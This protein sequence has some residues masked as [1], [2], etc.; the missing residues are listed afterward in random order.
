[1]T[2]ATT[3]TAFRNAPS[4]PNLGQAAVAPRAGRR[5]EL[6]PKLSFHIYGDLAAVESDWRRFERRADC[7]AFQTF[8][9]LASW[10]RHVGAREGVRPAIIVGRY[11]DDE[12]AFIMPLCVTPEHL[13]R[14]L[15]W[16][17]QELCDYNAPLLAPDFSQRVMREGFLALWR[18]LQA[19]MQCDPLLRYDWIEFEKMPQKIG[20]QINPFT[21][22]RVTPN[23]SGAHL[24][25]LA[26]NWEKFYTAK[27]SS[28]TRRRDRTKR[29][30]Y[31]GVRR[32]PLRYR[33]GAGRHPAHA[34]DADGAKK[35][36][37]GRAKELPT[38]LPGRDT[39]NSFST[40]R[41]IRNTGI[42]FTSA[43]WTSE[44]RAP[45][46]TSASCSAIATTTCSQVI[47]TA[48]SHTTVPGRCIYASS[49]LTR[50]A[51]A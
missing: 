15:C 26:E 51:W 12:I 1:M 40:S 23:P 36:I 27:R 4:P 29:T 39:A 11:S 35:P 21:Y 28:A 37:A 8:D 16:L 44:G 49:W 34:R 6:P 41:Q 14:R 46:P 18:E 32:N 9:W 45:P 42:C 19:Q 20:T 3:L 30:A 13:A 33:A 5:S 31:V 7:T 2:R 47:A 43:A 24:T 17:G 22:L 25:H 10:H 48:T 38:S 50:S